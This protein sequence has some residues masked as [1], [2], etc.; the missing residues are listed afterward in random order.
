MPGRADPGPQK[1]EA[2]MGVLTGPPNQGWTHTCAHGPAK[3]GPTLRGGPDSGPTPKK[4]T[5]HT[6]AL[7]PPRHNKKKPSCEV[8]VGDSTQTDSRLG[9]AHLLSKEG[10]AARRGPENGPTATQRIPDTRYCFRHTQTHLHSREGGAARRGPDAG[11]TAKQHTPQ[12][13]F[14]LMPTHSLSQGREAPRGGAQT[15]DRP[16]SST[17]HTHV[18]NSWSLSFSHGEEAP[19]GEAPKADRPEAA[20]ATHTR[21]RLPQTHLSAGARDPGVRRMG[22]LGL[23]LT[24]RR[25][26]RRRR[27]PTLRLR[28]WRPWPAGVPTGRYIIILADI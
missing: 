16:R 25:S 7:G 19:R 22:G 26:Q 18:S 9:R 10:G 6:H 20:H 5:P 24:D 21:I 13:R 27:F 3:R 17:H 12:T 28:P 11:P 4:H 8:L 1:E 15:A 14:H 2:R 23:G